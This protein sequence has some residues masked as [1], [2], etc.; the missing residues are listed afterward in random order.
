MIATNDIGKV[1]TSAQF[2]VKSKEE[3]LGP[4]SAPVF[5]GNLQDVNAYEGQ[6]IEF[7][8]EIKANP[9]PDL[10]W[11]FNSELIQAS[12]TILMSFDG[13]K[14]Q[15]KITKCETKNK[16]LYELTVSN[17]LG[18]ASSKATANVLGKS[19]PK[20]TERFT[21]REVGLSEQTKLSC[22]VTGFPAPDIEWYCNG[23]RV[24]PGLYY[25]II[26]DGEVCSLLIVRPTDKL[27][28]AY[29]CRAVNEC[30]SDS[31]KANISFV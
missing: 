17:Q 25:S 30:G 16:G 10:K 13:T 21:D 12:D 31:C 1:E 29:E 22:R 11:Y 5:V 26:R 19:A 7:T 3:D 6:T 8:A 23:I 14:A 15:L 28:G 20:F 9:I 27:S 2:T 4:Q 24:E 18:T